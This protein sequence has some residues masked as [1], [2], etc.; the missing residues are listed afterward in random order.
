[1]V[2]AEKPH[3]SS[4]KRGAHQQTRNG[5][6]ADG[7]LQER[8]Q[9]DVR[10]WAAGDGAVWMKLKMYSLVGRNLKNNER[11]SELENA[12][13]RDDTPQCVVVALHGEREEVKDQQDIHNAAEPL[14]DA[15][16]Y[17]E[18]DGA[19]EP[20]RLRRATEPAMQCARKSLDCR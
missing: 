12:L 3:A 18:A 16:E 17:S 20:D 6:P 2:Q 7:A 19:V 10:N 4:K 9:A 13:Q 11:E 8:G 14:Y 15:A 5:V 1:M